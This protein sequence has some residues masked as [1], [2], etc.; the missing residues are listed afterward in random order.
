MKKTLFLK[1]LIVGGLALLLLVPLSMIEGQI[2]ARNTRQIETENEIAELTAGR[3]QLVG[4]LVVVPYQEEV[5]RDETNPKTGEVVKRS[6]WEDRR[7]VLVPRS[8][9]VTS[10]ARVDERHRGLFKAQAYEI[11]AI[12]KGDIFMAKG[13]GLPA[14]RTIKPGRA[15]LVVGLTDLRGIRSQPLLTWNGAD[16]GFSPG[17]PCGIFNQGIHVDLG[18]AAALEGRLS[19]FTLPL[20]LK[21]SQSFFVAPV[22]E[23]TKVTLHSPWP[24]PSFQGRFTATHSEGPEGFTATWE[25]FHLARN[26][27]KILEGKGETTEAFGVA[28]LKG[29]NVYLKSE[30]A[31]KYGFLFVG[32]T[33]AAFFFFEML[34]RL[35]IHPIQYLLVGF[36][37]A[38][39]FLLLLSLSEQLS[40]GWAYLAASSACTLL[41]GAYLAQVLQSPRRGWGFAAGLGLLFAVLYALIDSEDNALLM[42][43]LLT[44]VGLAAVMIGTRKI[45]WYAL[46]EGETAQAE[47]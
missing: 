40:F 35:P 2:R 32:L 34:R 15:Y 5:T 4:P 11:D 37:L 6:Y 3:Q 10:E 38:I 39:F 13:L 28:F 44:F 18:P 12:V 21:G 26:L 27:A 9:V 41:L 24:T 22:A 23:S 31:V 1:S 8:L 7:Q 14:D 30:R 29:V 42:G 47:P 36:A 16:F 43:S 19:A 46:S 17:V 20:A 45:D 33:F 25:V